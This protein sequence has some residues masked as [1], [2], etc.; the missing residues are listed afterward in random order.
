MRAGGWSE[1]NRI[2]FEKALVAN[3]QVRS[4]RLHNLVYSRLRKLLFSN[5]RT[6]EDMDRRWPL[7][8]VALR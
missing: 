1:E 5:L 6:P 8:E 4:L 2:K 3:P 7:L